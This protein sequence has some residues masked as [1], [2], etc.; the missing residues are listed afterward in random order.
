M[1]SHSPLPWSHEKHQ[2]LLTRDDYIDLRNL[3]DQQLNAEFTSVRCS[4]DLVRQEL[5]NDIGLFRQ[6][7]KNDIGLVKQELKEFKDNV[8]AQNQ[9]LEA[10][11]RQSHAYMRNNA[12][13]NP[14]LPI[15]PVV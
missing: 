7:L 14:T 15:R 2:Q 1:T 12:L 3:Q 10:Q 13:K 6:E 8:K 4:I 9:R 11:I 5:K